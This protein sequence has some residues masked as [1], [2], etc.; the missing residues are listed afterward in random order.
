MEF[1]ETR[2]DRPDEGIWEVRGPRR[3]F[4]HSKVMAWVA[5]DRAVK[6]VEMFGREGPIEKWR[7]MRDRIHREVCDR[8]YDPDVGAFMQSYGSKFLDAS[9]LMMPLVGFLTAEDERMRGTVAAVEARLIHEGYVD[10]YE[11]DPA[12]DGLPPGEGSFLPCSFWLA[13]NYALMGRHRDAVTLFDRLLDIRND[14]G[15]LSEEYD[16]HAGRLVGN[17]P[18][19]F[20]H[21]GLINTAYNLCPAPRPPRRAAAA[22]LTTGR[23]Q[24]G[25]SAPIRKSKIGRTP[26]AC[27]PGDRRPPSSICRAIA[28]HPDRSSPSLTG[29]PPSR[30]ASKSAAARPAWTATPCGCP[31]RTFTPAAA[32]LISP[33]ST[34]AVGPLRPWACQSASQASWAS[35]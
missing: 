31:W 32:S 21:I 19:A 25:R 1:L 27:S 34:S 33:L 28:A 22:E 6:A 3:H 8:S 5:F 9:V 12:V 13:D 26:S 24:R 20:T 4:T 29:P 10:R 35:Q 15:L 30:A 2:W 17:F 14:L 7:A 16:V 23:P 18:Q 11:T